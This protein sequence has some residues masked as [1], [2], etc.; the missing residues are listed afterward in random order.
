MIYTDYR[1]I[2]QVELKNLCYKIQKLLIDGERKYNILLWKKKVG[3]CFYSTPD[4]FHIIYL[5]D[6]SKIFALHNA[7]TIHLHHK[8]RSS[9]E[10]N[11]QQQT[12]K[13]IK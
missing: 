10:S 12:K 5:K 6:K 9:I 1:Q 13:I 11:S 4:V 3:F 7:Q 8:E 2:V